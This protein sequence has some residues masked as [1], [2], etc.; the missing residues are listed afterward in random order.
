MIA[1]L[2][3]AGWLLDNPGYIQ[4]AKKGQYFLQKALIDENGELK[5]RW[6]KGEA[7]HAGQLDDY[8]F[9]AFALLELY[10]STFEIEYLQQAIYISELMISHFWD[11]E[12]DGF[13]LYSK[14]SEQLVSR[15]KETYDGAIPSGN[16]VAAVVLECLSKLTGETKWQEISYRQ[17]CFLTASIQEYPAG[18][19]MALLAVSQAVYSSFE[20]VCATAEKSIPEELITY[21]K[22]TPLPNLTLLVKTHENKEE[23]KQVAHFTSD[24]P[25]PETGTMYYLCHNG[26]CSAPFNDLSALFEQLHMEMGK[27]C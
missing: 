14:D 21:L 2:A 26:A 3:K 27:K 6:R 15:P 1:A 4:T 9:Y 10:K 19:S 5:I 17:F 13:F 23:L 12:R 25:I 18:H 16:S 8:A 7:A 22:K 20:L 11:Q 24:Y